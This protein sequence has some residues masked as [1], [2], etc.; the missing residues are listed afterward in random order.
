VGQWTG[1]GKRTKKEFRPME[2]GSPRKK[3]TKGK[4]KRNIP[5]RKNDPNAKKSWWR[6]QK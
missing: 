1:K 4:R 5:K 6:W 2:V 3:S